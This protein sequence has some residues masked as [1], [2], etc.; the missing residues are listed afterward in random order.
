MIKQQC[1]SIDSRNDWE[2]A[3]RG[4]KHAFAHTWENCHAMHLTTGYKTYLYYFESGD[5]RILCPIAERIF[6]D[7]V[8][9]VT[10]YGFS[11]FVGSA[12]YP[13]ISHYWSDFVS[14]KGYICG[15]IGL[16]PIFENITYFEAKDA[17]QYN[18]VY[19]LDLTL[20]DEE[21]F[22]NLSVNRKRQLKNWE[23]SLSHFVFDKTILIDFFLANYPEFIRSNKL[24]PVYNFTNE[25]LSF[26]LG[27]DNVLIIGMGTPDKVEA[28][29]VFAHTPYVGDFLFNISLPSGRHHSVCLLWYAVKYLKSLQIPLLNLGGGVRE[30]DSLDSFKQRFG[31]RKKPLKCLKQIYKPDIYKKLCLRAGVA[32]NNMGGYFPAYRN[33]VRI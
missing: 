7:Y 32:P 1:I 18:W 11:G 17:R 22:E 13:D 12:D 16:N 31:G 10:P 9:I 2:K 19:V 8:D 30:G 23:K 24:A 25:T 20:R 33:L 3:L 26:L 14:Q 27:L 21:L 28:V 6:D 29:S 15:Y 4:I 5:I